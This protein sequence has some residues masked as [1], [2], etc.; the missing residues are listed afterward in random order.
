MILHV[1]GA[2]AAAA[3]ANAAPIMAKYLAYEIRNVPPAYLG[4]GLEVTEVELYE[5]KTGANTANQS[6]ASASESNATNPPSLMIDGDLNTFWAGAD[7]NANTRAVTLR[8]TYPTARSLHH[9]FIKRGGQTFRFF[10]QMTIWASNTPNDAASWKQIYTT[11]YLDIFGRVEFYPSNRI[12]YVNWADGGI[13]YSTM[14]HISLLDDANIDYANLGTWTTFNNDGRFYAGAGVDNLSLVNQPSFV[15]SCRGSVG[16]VAYAPKDDFTC[17]KIDMLA[18]DAT[19]FPAA[20]APAET[21]LTLNVTY[22]DDGGKTRKLGWICGSAREFVPGEKRRF[23]APQFLTR[24]R[25]N[26]GVSQGDTFTGW[27]R[28]RLKRKNGTYYDG[29]LISI[30]ASSFASRN[31]HPVYVNDTNTSRFWTTS[32]GGGQAT[33]WLEFAMLNGDWSD[34]GAIEVTARSD[35]PSSSA[36]SIAL[37]LDT[38]AGA[39]P[40]PGASWSGYA[41]FGAGETRTFTIPG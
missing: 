17:T 40:I 26:F 2:A 6:T 16:L 15:Y 37:T 28:F 35:T 3:A 14:V 23:Y 29:A 20:A 31:F 41:A 19:N 7:N 27:D 8:F 12:W 39:Q 36:S 38:G 9:I 21:P 34:I 25:A 10:R 18:K 22:S 11:L 32:S 13:D 5:T 30:T 24:I 33:S 1:I 4:D